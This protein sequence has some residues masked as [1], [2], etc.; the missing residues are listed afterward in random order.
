MLKSLGRSK[1]VQRLLGW[2]LGTYLIAVHRTSRFVLEPAD[3]YERIDRQMPIIVA[4]WHGQHFMMPFTKRPHDKVSVLISRHGDG[5][6]NARAASRLGLGLIRGAGD[7]RRRY[8][9]KGGML[10]LREML[11]T[12]QAGTSV[13]LTADVPKGPARHAGLGIVTLAQ[14]S[15]RPIVPIAVATSRY[16][17]LNSWDKAAVNLPFSKGAFVFGDPIQVPRNVDE[18]TLET[19]RQAV[20]DELNKVTARAYQI[21][22]KKV[23]E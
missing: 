13:A 23:G 11:R 16:L 14:V 22:D 4:M 6:I 5:E 12:L 17:Q 7:A 15:G 3:A 2:V 18:G 9:K 10:A 1:H 20:E 21:V 8:H 19:Y